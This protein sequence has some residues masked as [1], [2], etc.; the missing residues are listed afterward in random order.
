MILPFICHFCC[1]TCL[2]VIENV[3]FSWSSWTSSC[4][5][6]QPMQYVW[7]RMWNFYLMLTC[8]QVSWGTWTA[9][10]DSWSESSAA[11]SILQLAFRSL[12]L[13]VMALIYS[14]SACNYQQILPCEWVRV[15]RNQFWFS[16]EDQTP[17]GI[18]NF[19]SR[20][21]YTTRNFPYLLTPCLAGGQ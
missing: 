7:I 16:A 10:W 14:V 18:G 20:F 17:F 15:Q 3:R 11:Y 6:Q 21:K 5:A 9:K 8:F 4:S 1:R 2:K 13:R 19:L 12:C